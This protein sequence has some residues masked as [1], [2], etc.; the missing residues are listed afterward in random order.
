MSA[1]DPSS[2][3]P[4]LHAT[5]SV[6]QLLL[7]MEVLNSSNIG[8]SSL[9][10]DD[11]DDKI[12]AARFMSE[13]T[14]PK[15]SSPLPVGKYLSS[16]LY[17]AASPI[18]RHFFRNDEV[19]PPS[20]VTKD[21]GLLC[22]VM[23]V[24]QLEAAWIELRNSWDTMSVKKRKSR[25]GELVVQGIPSSVRSVVWLLLTQTENEASIRKLYQSLLRRTSSHADAIK[26]EIVLVMAAHAFLREKLEV[27]VVARVVEACVLNDLQCS[28]ITGLVYLIMILLIQV[29]E[30]DCFAIVSVVMNDYQLRA[31]YIET[32]VG[33]SFM[34]I[35]NFQLMNLIND[36]MPDLHSHFKERGVQ[37][38][39][40]MSLWTHSVFLNCLPLPVVLHVVDY[41]LV[42]GNGHG[43]GCHVIFL[44]VALSLL[45]DC[46]EDILKMDKT[47]IMELLT[48]TLMLRYGNIIEREDIDFKSPTESS[49]QIIARAKSIHIS[50]RRLK[51]LK[52][53]YEENISASR[54]REDRLNVLKMEVEE[55]EELLE[56][57][58]KMKA[59]LET[60]AKK[61]HEDFSRQV[62]E[63]TELLEQQDIDTE[64]LQQEN[65]SLFAQLSSEDAQDVLDAFRKDALHY[66]GEDSILDNE[67]SREKVHSF[68]NPQSNLRNQNGPLPSQKR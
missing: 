60:E 29:P 34:D 35:L 68:E 54:D 10:A 31:L 52:K 57:R 12:R 11:D 28:S 4:T 15:G 7:K 33:V 27:D 59:S 44:S 66:L 47:G 13:P 21:K 58:E 30:E 48:C 3:S 20:S 5:P 49:R 18:T 26:R 22:P 40:F 65:K 62:M 53:Y 56:M 67:T 42:N 14:I 41:L 23:E 51:Q 17:M 64:Q 24:E 50:S 46:K 63:L 36:S 37:E 2:G 6:K 38:T 8:I 39:G 43:D 16:Q 45:H 32:E 61:Q 55:L 1:S 19:T 9:A 25:A